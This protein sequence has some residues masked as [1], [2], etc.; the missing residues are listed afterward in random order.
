MREDWSSLKARVER[1]ED[2]YDWSEDPPSRTR[3]F[4]SNIFARRN[5]EDELAVDN[6]LLVF[7]S[8]G[9]T[10][11]Y[12]LISCKDDTN[13]YRPSY[14]LA[15]AKLVPLVNKVDDRLRELL[16]VFPID[17]VATVVEYFHADLRVLLGDHI[18]NRH[19]HLW[20]DGEIVAAEDV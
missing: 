8:Q 14:L 17:N 2:E 3:R 9:D 7:R 4:V 12:D 11:S 13:T 16:G 19:G 15:S 18:V 6:Y 1:L 5:S 20:R 10:A